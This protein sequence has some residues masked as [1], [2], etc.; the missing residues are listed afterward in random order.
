VKITIALL[1]AVV[2][3][4]V[5]AGLA[6]AQIGPQ[7]APFHCQNREFSIVTSGPYNT[8]RQTLVSP[9]L[10]YSG[11][12]YGML[13]VKDPAAPQANYIFTMVCLNDQEF[14][15]RAPNG[16]YVSAELGYSGSDNGMLRARATAIGSWERFRFESLYGITNYRYDGAFK[17]VANGKYVSVEQGYAQTDSRYAM[18]RAR[19]TAIG[20]WERLL[21]H[22]RDGGGFA[23]GGRCFDT[24]WMTEA[25]WEAYQPPFGTL[26]PGQIGIKVSFT[27]TT[28]A[29]LLARTAAQWDDIW[30]DL[31][32]CIGIP[33][34]DESQL[35]SVYK[36]LAC[37][38]VF[39][40]NEELG[41]PTWDFESHRPDIPWVDVLNPLVNEKCNWGG[42][43]SSSSLIGSLIFQPSLD[44]FLNGPIYQSQFQPTPL[45]RRFGQPGTELQNSGHRLP[46][47]A[48]A[49][50]SWRVPPR[51]AFP[52]SLSLRR[53]LDPS[54][55]TTPAR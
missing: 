1:A 43:G 54:M 37:H 32:N 29:R 49:R 14:A 24:P 2:F 46:P 8:F 31:Q 19:A 40:V 17:S 12:N 30:A 4:A 23:M 6:Q 18:L 21:L 47:S 48:S 15:I 44:R 3:V 25:H 9:E 42:G 38:A 26:P 52:A 11:P 45:G 27:P 7:T 35:N 50:L 39:G 16:R 33:I 28:D 34:Y 22:W 5:L 20:P 10:A 51:A 53:Q 36:Q 13:R 55:T 41:G